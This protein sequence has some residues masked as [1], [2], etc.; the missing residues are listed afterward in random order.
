MSEVASNITRIY[1]EG[2]SESSYVF[3]ADTVPPRY[4]VVDRSESGYWGASGPLTEGQ[5]GV[6]LADSDLGPLSAGEQAIVHGENGIGYSVEELHEVE[7]SGDYPGG[8]D[9]VALNLARFVLG[10]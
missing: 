7:V 8:H 6:N 1:P 3:A 9:R 10:G 2:V 5:L 4:A